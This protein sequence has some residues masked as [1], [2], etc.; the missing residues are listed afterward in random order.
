MQILS[1]SSSDLEVPSQK[2]LV[3]LPTSAVTA[4]AAALAPPPICNPVTKMKKQKGQDGKKKVETKQ[5]VAPMKILQ[6]DEPKDEIAV[7]VIQPVSVAAVP[8][9]D[10]P[11]VSVSKIDLGDI[12]SIVQRSITTQLKTHDTELISSLKNIIA[13]EVRSVINSSFK[14]AEKATEQAVQRG[15]ASGL[16]TGLKKGL[17]GELGK[18]LDKHAKDSVASATKEALECMQPLIMN[19]L[20]QVCVH[21]TE[22][23]TMSLSACLTFV[24]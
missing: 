2:K 3:K 16:S 22:N 11:V 18:R 7:E 12:E 19:S 4:V 20:H 8:S 15:I 9:A 14:D 17:D 6:R 21:S 10:L 5:T 24:A 23:S 13:A 1:E